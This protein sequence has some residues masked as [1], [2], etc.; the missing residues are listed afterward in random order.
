[1]NIKSR[2]KKIETQTG[3]TD[4]NFCRCK[5]S[6]RKVPD[7]DCKNCGKDFDEFSIKPGAEMRVIEP[8]VENYEH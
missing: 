2:L 3:G 1:M 7:R 6:Y 4:S 8:T 5:A